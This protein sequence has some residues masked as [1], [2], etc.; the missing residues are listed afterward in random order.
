MS[1]ILAYTSPA[2]GHIFPLTPTLQALAARGHEIEVWT[3]EAAVPAM[4]AEGFDAHAVGPAISAIEHDDWQ[5]KNPRKALERSVAAMASRARP[6]VAELAP[7]LAENPPD[8]L[9]VDS[10]CFGGLAAAEAWGGPWAAFC[11]FPLAITSRDAPPFGPGF[12]PARGPLG[13]TRD[14]I[15]PNRLC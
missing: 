12:A 5:T 6:E 14:A 13:R 4:L 15:C 2:L 11:P 1:R 9:I 7:M 10:N 3:H 8:A